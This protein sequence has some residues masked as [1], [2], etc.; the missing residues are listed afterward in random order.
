MSYRQVKDENVCS[1]SHGLVE[2]DN[3]NN[4]EVANEA[5]DDDKGEE[6]W[7]NDWDNNH[8]NLKMFFFIFLLRG[9]VWSFF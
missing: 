4:E 8:Q 6:N 1:V 5:D 2:N 9:K 3:K 7:D